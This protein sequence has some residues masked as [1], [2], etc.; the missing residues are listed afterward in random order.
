MR[1]VYNYCKIGKMVGTPPSYGNRERT[2]IRLTYSLI[3]MSVRFSKR[4][5]YR[6]QKRTRTKRSDKNVQSYFN[7]YNFTIMME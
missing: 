2:C 1:R 3:V 5:K 4:D 7:N 6:I